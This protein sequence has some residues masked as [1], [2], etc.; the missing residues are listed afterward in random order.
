MKL[1]LTRIV[2]GGIAAALLSGFV[3]AASAQSAGAQP[4][5][6]NV[7]WS[8]VQ[9]QDPY[10]NKP[11]SVMPRSYTRTETKPVPAAR[12]R[13]D[14]WDYGQSYQ[15]YPNTRVAAADPAQRSA[16]GNSDALWGYISELRFGVM[17]HD[18]RFPSRHEFHMPNPF[19]NRYEGGVNVNPEVIF[20]SPDWLEWAYSPRPRVGVSINTSGD[21]N[22]AYTSLGWDTAWDNGIYLDGFFG[23]AVHDGELTDGNPQGKIEFGSRVLFHLGGDIGWRWDEHNGIALVWEHMS[24]GSMLASKNQGIDSLGLRYSYRF[25]SPK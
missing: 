15:T 8:M 17:G 13:P 21:T 22:S 2:S 18:V 9:A 24:N 20:T 14:P 3:Q 25:D 10:F 1:N 16:Y 23:L 11:A 19:E 5:A 4:Q 12:T 6:S 7:F